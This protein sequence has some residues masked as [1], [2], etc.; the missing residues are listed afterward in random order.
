MEIQFSGSYQQKQ[1]YQGVYLAHKPSRRST[2]LRITVFFIVAALYT[3]LGLTQFRQGSSS[4]PQIS[5]LLGQGITLVVVATFV[6]Q[7]YIK[8][9][10]Q[11]RN[12]WNDPI[13]RLPILGSISETGIRFGASA[14]GRAIS[15][16]AFTKAEKTEDLVVLVTGD[17]GMVIL[18]RPFFQS[19]GD[20]NT[21]QQWT[22]E[23]I[24]DPA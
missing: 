10:V 18:P 14:S 23:K 8:A 15:W 12:S 6:F 22:Q 3:G 17:S 11:S 24:S 20:W 7:P 2:L 9:F 13:T 16:D 4:T 19:E 5:V 21:L 1:F